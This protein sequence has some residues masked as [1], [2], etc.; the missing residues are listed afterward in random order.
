MT[1]SNFTIVDN[2]DGTHRIECLFVVY[3]AKF[4]HHPDFLQVDE[5]RGEREGFTTKYWFLVEDDLSAEDAVK[6]LTEYQNKYDKLITELEDD[7]KRWNEFPF[8]D[9]AIVYSK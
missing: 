7:D 8:K 9:N 1:A 2:K 4:G 3:R 6:K 5:E